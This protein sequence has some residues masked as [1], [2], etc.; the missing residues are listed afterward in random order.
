MM[1]HRL[2]AILSVALLNTAGALSSPLKLT[3]VEAP[4]PLDSPVL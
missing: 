3:S 4:P 2:A 1:A